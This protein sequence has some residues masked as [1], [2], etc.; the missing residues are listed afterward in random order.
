M[1]D[2]HTEGA[3]RPNEKKNHVSA[4]NS[5]QW[6]SIETQSNKWTEKTEEEILSEVQWFDVESIK[7]KDI[8]DGKKTSREY[9]IQLSGVNVSSL[10]ELKEG[11]KEFNDYI[12][13]LV[14]AANAESL[15]LFHIYASEDEDYEKI[16]EITNN[17]S[18]E[19]SLNQKLSGKSVG[20]EVIRTKDG[21]ELTFFK[22]SVDTEKMSFNQATTVFEKAKTPIKYLAEIAKAKAAEEERKRAEMSAAKEMADLKKQLAEQAEMIKQLLAAQSK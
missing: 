21:K 19:W 1:K 13:A 14:S 8:T 10:K 16:M 18:L 20:K 7:Y 11:Y 17:L 9:D 3:I 6:E 4:T 15:R 12:N 2:M 22:Y 5:E